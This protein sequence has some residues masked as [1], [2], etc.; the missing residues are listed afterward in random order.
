MSEDGTR[1]GER[2]RFTG[3]D[4]TDLATHSAG[5][6]RP[7]LPDV[8][9]R[10]IGRFQVLHRAGKGAMGVVYAAYDAEL[11]RRVAI[12]LLLSD[13]AGPDY[14]ARLNDEARVMARV[15]HGNVVAVHD[16]GTWEGRPYIAMDFVDGSDLRHWLRQMR[17]WEEVVAVFVQAARGLAAAHAEGVIHRDFKPDNVLV[18]KGR[19]GPIARV[20]DF[21]VASATVSPDLLSRTDGDE[22]S[23]TPVASR[24]GAGTPAY[25]APERYA[26][27]AADARSDQFAFCV[28]LFEALAGRR[29]FAGGSLAELAA[30]ISDGK[31]T[32]PPTDTKVPR[33]V[34]R[35]IERG[36]ASDPA[37]RFRSMDALIAA[38]T[39]DP[40]RRRRALAATGAA[41]LLFGGS[42]G[43]YAYAQHRQVARCEQEAE[44]AA[45]ELWAGKPRDAAAS[46]FARLQGSYVAD[47][48]D[49]VRDG[50]DAEVGRWQGATAELCVAKLRASIPES[51]GAARSECLEHRRDAIRAFVS[52]L[53]DVDDAK[54]STAPMGLGQLPAVTD[55]ADPRRSDLL[56]LP[57][58][59]RL[60]REIYEV[61]RANAALLARQALGGR[62][63]GELDAARE[64]D[65]RASATAY[66]PVMAKAAYH[67][68]WV[69]AKLG[70]I[71][72]AEQTFG[73][74]LNLAAEARD[75]PLVA[76]A[77]L[78]LLWFVGATAPERVD[79]LARGAKAAIEALDEPTERRARLASIQ[80]TLLGRAKDYEAAIAHS[81]SALE[82]WADQDGQE[83]ELAKAHNNLGYVHHQKGDLSDA[84]E[85]Y[86]EALEIK[87]RMLGRSHPLL[88]T[89]LHNLGMI[90]RQEKDLKAA[91]GYIARALV[92][93]IESV[94]EVHQR[95]ASVL[96][97]LAAIHNDRD[98]KV[99]ARRAAKRALAITDRLDDPPTW[100]VEELRDELTRTEG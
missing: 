10:T 99:Q 24:S 23:Q 46:A 88:A 85:H 4:D 70:R 15:V 77:W 45:Q 20:A 27:E 5:G 38:L 40:R 97:E 95:T 34:W 57:D 48:W 61:R 83:L 44:D 17:G 2:P 9:P 55:C 16:V 7:R 78:S 11:D 90:A 59:A 33:W 76:D 94:G 74:V 41:V 98:D 80:G 75:A 65:V 96:L 72:E 84:A 37:E 30:A 53:G 91:R 56:P 3:E 1:T 13:D 25:M 12:K 47:A 100:L 66:P 69:E 49:R 35:V 82:L 26:G 19:A 42:A 50:L 51:V 31:R 28:S 81:E 29:P 89:T 8:E 71:D 73:R 68:G 36:L 67:R 32:P 52:L 54:A 43:A 21:G 92:L 60:R 22:V 58:D 63:A 86:R 87:E 93:M 14:A 79:D 62:F 6:G 18:A 39:H 64:T